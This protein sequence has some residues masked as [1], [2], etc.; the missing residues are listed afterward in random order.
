MSQV[1]V[2]QKNYQMQI[3]KRPMNS[4]EVEA[5]TLLQS[6]WTSAARR[7]A[8]CAIPTAILLKSSRANRA[9]LSSK[10]RDPMK[11]SVVTAYT[12]AT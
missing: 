5:P 12:P 6:Q 2:E 8:T 7:A 3:F 10:G 4:G 11:A 9:S 1:Q